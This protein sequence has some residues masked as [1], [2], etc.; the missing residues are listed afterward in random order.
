[1][2]PFLFDITPFIYFDVK[3][4]RGFYAR[5]LISV[6]MGP[7]GYERGGLPTSA[8]TGTGGGAPCSRGFV[9]LKRMDVALKDAQ[10]GLTK[11]VL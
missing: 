1:M 8:P 6:S 5:S 10:T 4:A 7:L 11:S 3:A 2:C 9:L